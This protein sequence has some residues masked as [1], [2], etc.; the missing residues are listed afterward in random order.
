MKKLLTIISIST[1]LFSCTTENDVAGIEDQEALNLE[2]Q[3][4]NGKFDTSNFGIYEGTF[5]TFDGSHRATILIEMDGKSK[6]AVS[7]LFPT[8]DLS[9]FRSKENLTKAKAGKIHFEGDDF[10]FDFQVGAD[11]SNPLVS[12][13]TYKGKEAEAYIVKETSRAPVEAKTGSYTCETGCYTDTEDPIPHPELGAPGAVQSFNF[14]LSGAAGNSPVNIQFTLN[15]RIYNGTATQGNCANFDGPGNYTRC[16]LFAEPDLLG[17]SGPIRFR[18]AVSETVS[19]AR[20]IYY[21]ADNSYSC[22]TYDGTAFYTSSLFGRSV[23][24]F[25][26]DDPLQSGGDC[27]NFN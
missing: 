2:E 14:V 3:V 4:A 7:F 21:S 8:G 24:A 16:G 15:S 26:T 1:L 17:N 13:M 9:A 12:N 6:P 18:S 27:F 5:T 19:Q 11:G 10:S 23:I 25:S 22:S 20:H